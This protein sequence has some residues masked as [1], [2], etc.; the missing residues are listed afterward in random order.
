MSSSVME[1]LG[2]LN[3]RWGVC[4]FTSTFYAMYDQNPGTRSWLVN[5]T[6]VYSVLYE[7]SDYLKA[8]QGAGSKLL[9]DITEFTQSFGAPYDTFTVENYIQ[10]IDL[11]SETTRRVLAFGNDADRQDF[12]TKLKRYPLFGI[13]LPP[14][15]VA[16]YIERQW[17]WKATITE[18]KA[19]DLTCDAIVGVFKPNDA[20]MKLYHGLRHYLYRGKGKYYSWGKSF[21]LLADAA[22]HVGSNYQICYAIEIRKY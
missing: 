2:Q 13:A 3:E 17:K 8:L 11:T 18:Y 15:A 21:D 20:S 9:K 1:S 5:A 16:D 6:Q 12:E 10:T 4:G 22:A 7:I 19:G 14:Q